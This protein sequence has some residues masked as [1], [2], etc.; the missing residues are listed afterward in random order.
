MMKGLIVAGANTFTDFQLR[1]SVDTCRGLRGVFFDPTR[2]S[3]KQWEGRKR[4]I[5][6]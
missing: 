5:A 6:M 2:Y 1:Y 3:A 4:E